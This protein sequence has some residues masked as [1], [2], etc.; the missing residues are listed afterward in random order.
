[1]GREVIGCVFLMCML[2]F[3]CLDFRRRCVYFGFLGVEG[4]YDCL[5]GDVRFVLVS[6]LRVSEYV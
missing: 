1:M 6:I 2:F 4:L 5:K 3:L